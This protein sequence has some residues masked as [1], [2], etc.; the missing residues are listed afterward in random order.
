[1][2]W[3]KLFLA[4]YK[5]I[6]PPSILIVLL[7]LTGEAK[8]VEPIALYSLSSDNSSTTDTRTD[9]DLLAHLGNYR[10]GMITNGNGNEEDNTEARLK[11]IVIENKIPSHAS[12]IS[13]FFEE[14]FGSTPPSN[15]NPMADDNPFSS[16]MLFE[17][18]SILPTLTTYPNNNLMDIDFSHI[19]GLDKKGISVGLGGQLPSGLQIPIGRL[20]DN[21]LNP[22]SYFFTFTIRF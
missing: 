13:S 4:Y 7:V 12:S 18:L 14:Y 3:G 22:N 8:A 2:K 16:S 20:Q 19:L 11:Q 15:N 17:T 10:A 1:M 6:I 21:S 9:K 5:L